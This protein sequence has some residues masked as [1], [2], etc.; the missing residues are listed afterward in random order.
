[1]KNRKRVKRTKRRDRTLNY[2]AAVAGWNIAAVQFNKATRVSGV[3]TVT[4]SLEDL[5]RQEEFSRK[6]K[7]ETDVQQNLLG[8]QFTYLLA[9]KRALGTQALSWWCLCTCGK[10]V[11][12]PAFSLVRGKVRD[13][14]CRARLAYRVQKHRNKAAR[15]AEREDRRRVQASLAARKRRP[16][17]KF[18]WMQPVLA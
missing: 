4:A 18:A 16:A 6:R 13:C 8:C 5:Q 9:W 1:M 3:K 17:M 15:K 7:K 10:S 12:V 14:G 2:P 11:Q